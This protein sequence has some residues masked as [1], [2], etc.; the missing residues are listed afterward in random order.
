MA[1]EE[2][3]QAVVKAALA[4]FGKIDVLVNN[5]G[6]FK[7]GYL[8]E[9]TKESFVSHFN[10][11]QLGVFLGMKSVTEAMIA[12]GGGSIVNISSGAGQRGYPGIFA[13]LSTKWAV[14]GMTKAVARELAEHKIR[15]NSA[16]PQIDRRR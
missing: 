14:T 6:I 11:N 16:G 12:N 9:T 5:A 3:W 7:S 13:Y 15:V 8:V 2:Q 1:D 10:V 4:A